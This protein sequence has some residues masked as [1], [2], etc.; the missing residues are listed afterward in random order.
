MQLRFL[1]LFIFLGYFA[2][3]VLAMKPYVPKIVDAVSEPWRWKNF[4]ELE[5][6]G[7][8]DIAEGKDGTIWIGADEGVF[9]YNGY[10]WKL[11]KNQENGLTDVPIKHVLI[12]K[13]GK[14]F[15]ISNH[16]VFQYNGDSWQRILNTPKSFN[17]SFTQA[18]ELSDESI[19]VR[20]NHGVLH[21]PSTLNKNPIFYTSSSRIE[22]LKSQNLNFTWKRFPETLLNG[23]D[24]SYVSDVL[25]EKSGAIWFA[26]TFGESG[27][28][29]RFNLSA[30]KSPYITDYELF[31]SN[32]KIAFGEGQKLIQSHDE[33]IW[34]INSSSRVPIQIFSKGK[35]QTIQLSDFFVTDE[36]AND[37]VQT[38]DGT[39]WIGALGK[40]YAFKDAKWELYDSP[41][42]KIPAN[43]L[44][45]YKS[46]NN[47]LWIAGLRSKVYYL[48]YSFNKWITYQGL[49]FQCEVSAE[50]EWFIDI[51]GNAISKNGNRW[52]AWGI[53]DGLMDAPVRII[54]TQQGQIWAAG[55][56]QGVAAT[57]YLKNEK[58]Y[59]QI[60]P[61]LSWGIDYR[62]VFEAKDGSIWFGG[63]VD[64]EIEKGQYGGVLQLTNPLESKLE[65]IH[66]KTK[67][68]GLDKS[69]AYGIGQTPDGKIWTGGSNLV[70]LDGEN[71]SYMENERLNQYINTVTNTENL[72]IVGSRYYGIFIFDGKNWTNYN[73]ESGLANN[74]IISIDAISDND[75]WV[76]TGNDICHFDGT[77][78]QTNIFPIEMNMDFEGG[79]IKHSEDGSIWIN[80]SDRSWKRRAYR[81]H[82]KQNIYNNFITHKFTPDQLPP[83][84]NITFFSKEVSA[85]GNTLI[86]WTGKDFFEETSDEKLLYSY[87]LNN[88]EWSTF[89]STVQN[90]FVSL[91]NGDY[92]MEVRAMDLGGN[93]DPTPAMIEFSVKPP[94]WKQAWFIIL[95][96]SFLFIITIFGYNIFTKNKKLE[97]LNDN[98]HLVNKKLKSKGKKI[99]SQN[100]EILKQ[101]KLI[102]KQKQSLESSNLN[103]E[104]QNHEIQT[105]RDRLEMMVE[106][107]E[108]LSKAKLSFFT[109][110]S[111]ELRTPLTLIL[112]PIN[113]LKNP[114][115]PLSKEER[116]TLYE[117]VNRNASRLLKL[118]NQILEIRRIE[119][120]SLDLQ[121]NKINLEKFLSRITSFFQ[122]LSKKR[123]IILQYN[124]S[125]KNIPA[126]L[127]TDKVEKIVVNLLANSFKHTPQFGTIQLNLRS[128]NATDWDLPTL[129]PSYFL[130]QVKD[131]GKGI[132]PEMMEYIFERYFSKKTLNKKEESSGIGLS[133]IKD[134]V[135]L[136]QGVIRVESQLGE[137]SQFDVFIPLIPFE[138]TVPSSKISTRDFEYAQREIEATIAEINES[139]IAVNTNHNI[140]STNSPKLLVVEDNIDMVTFLYG[141]LQKNFQVTTAKNGK[142]ALEAVQKE[143]FDLILSDIMMP[144]MDG[145]E[146]CQKIKSN[147]I[148]SHIPVILLTAKSLEEHQ[149]EGYEIGA[150]DY[151]SKPFN[152][153]MLELK[154][155]NILKQR[156]AFQT[157][158]NREF[159][160]TPKDI[161]LTSPDE[162]MLEKLV[163]LMEENIDNSNF[164]VNA[165]CESVNLSHM[166]FIR[167][168][169]KLTGKR[170]IDLLKSFRM[171]RAKDLLMQNK[172]TIAE[173]AYSVGFDMPSSF[174][175]AFKKEFAES[176]SHFVNRSEK[177]N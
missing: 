138:E 131:T 56:H 145:L 111:H 121:L 174:S 77:Q 164:N 81:N 171:K 144:E 32:K 135:E 83:E 1:Y 107:V 25:E 15:A 78:W 106:Q 139:L 43:K 13:K 127:D 104:K 38:N 129:H 36:Y 119:N 64:S 170:P 70:F 166:H 150:D 101:Q 71:W 128:V 133:Y 113:Q 154:I 123:N 130:I 22:S 23:E 82:K 92:K 108:E 4:P 11:H 85:D 34:I 156:I 98:L 100:K 63:S 18:I 31:S 167:K 20:S 62:A 94:V 53:E 132:A 51:K 46:P 148:T 126:M 6:K 54:V 160:V 9:E 97:K 175:R 44:Q 163:K 140:T 95:V 86:Q 60:H 125:I 68:K 41:N 162:E 35:W 91:S 14:V 88:G 110:I 152:P 124:S 55:S 161:H 149:L 37:I 158:L 143:S 84:T 72:L 50:E 74:T 80:R 168:I 155:G 177:N 153:K 137:G 176:P 157:K 3:D 21:L 99:N 47:K 67:E 115:S 122:N 165:M 40:L 66:F 69:N 30:E 28:L 112:G 10:E 17:F 49:N 57:A 58:W 79:D 8:R 24:F 120:S 87:R 7:V 5:G 96:G 52:I 42:Y 59:R 141:L 134:L 76:A 93:I 89:S 159:Q 102:L 12:T 105:Q 109:N 118:I 116:N 117:I 29:L 33:K 147:L 173:V 172:L 45:L 90:T 39:I 75:I 19:M 136:H 27:K 61:A 151:I 103:L 146:F 114:N 65:W 73:K 142:E 16:Q 2:I 48:D 26:F 169:K